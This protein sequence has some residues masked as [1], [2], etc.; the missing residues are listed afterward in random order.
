[1]TQAKHTPG[2][3]KAERYTIYASHFAKAEY[4][5]HAPKRGLI[6]KAFRQKD[7]QLIAAAPELLR[8]LQ[9]IV[10]RGLSMTR[11]EEARDAIAK[12]TGSAA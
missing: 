8:L 4:P 6:A 11:V 2:N 12:A 3:W 1:M 9:E 7:A 10:D 5:I